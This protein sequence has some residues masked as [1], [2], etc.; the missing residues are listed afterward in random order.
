MYLKEIMSKTSKMELLYEDM[1]YGENF[2]L[3][4]ENQC[5]IW[6]SY[7]GKFV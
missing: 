4:K 5:I 6:W 1:F 2:C 7:R 3:S